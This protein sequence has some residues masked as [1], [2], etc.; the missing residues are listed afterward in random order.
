M[1]QGS[2]FLRFGLVDAD[3]N[4]DDANRASR[5]FMLPR[6]PR[7]PCGRA[8]TQIA[9]Q[10]YL[11]VQLYVVH[12][13]IEYQEQQEGVQGTEQNLQKRVQRINQTAE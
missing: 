13:A 4:R 3:Y 7:S 2:T 10:E 12:E 6:P 5:S 11:Q 8:E 9:M 1:P